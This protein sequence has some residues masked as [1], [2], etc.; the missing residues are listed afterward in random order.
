M[1]IE[2]IKSKGYKEFKYLYNLKQHSELSIKVN[3]IIILFQIVKFF[4]NVSIKHEL[5]F[6]GIVK[7][8]ECMVNLSLLEENVK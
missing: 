2:I 8:L 4:K 5:D 7:E 1:P 3:Q 6:K